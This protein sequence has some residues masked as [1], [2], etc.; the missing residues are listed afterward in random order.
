MFVS[1][2][3]FSVFLILSSSRGQLTPMDDSSLGYRIVFGDFVLYPEVRQVFRH[4]TRIRSFRPQ[5][6]AFT[7][8]LAEKAGTMVSKEYLKSQLWPGEAPTKN[9][10]NALASSVWA[11]LGDNNPRKRKYFVATGH[12]GYCFTHPVE[13]VEP[14]TTFKND[15]AERCYRA[16]RHAMNDRRESSLRGAVAQFKRAI[17]HNPSHG[18]AWVGLSVAKIVMGIHC[19][20]APADA[21][22]KARFAAEEAIRIDGA[23]PEALASL[24]WVKLCYDRDWQA[25]GSGFEEAI[26]RDDK[27]AFAHNG[28]S[29]LRLVTGCA[30]KT[31]ASLKTARA[32]SPLSPPLNALLCHALYV[33]RRYQ[34][35]IDAGLK[36]VASDPES[37][38]AHGTLANPLLRLGRHEEAKRH[39]WE[40]CTLSDESKVYMGW[41]GYACGLTGQREKAEA[42]LRCLLATPGHEYTPSYFV[43]LIH[44]ALGRN[45]EAIHW[46]ERACEERSHWVLFLNADP[47][48]DGLRSEP[49]F[50]NLLERVGFEHV[51]RCA[52]GDAARTFA[53][54]GI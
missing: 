17:D 19:V 33:T 4:G 49:R 27:C 40:A 10:L 3:L 26:L 25:S 2:V 1:E 20:E 34:D 7:A 24:A 21:F 23:I 45:H 36:A 39:F 16:G 52:P 38:I 11:Q 47:I 48:F 29:L 13:R 14:L 51:D 9:R 12:E 35:A 15:L 18:L 43:A 32:A 54:Y 31:V 44:L 30:E 6:V 5:Q 42:V 50:L 46:L 53:H 37:C 22:A 8:L 28:L 41:W